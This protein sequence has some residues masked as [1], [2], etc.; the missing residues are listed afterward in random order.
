M[1]NEAESAKS[2]STA[3][4]YRVQ[5]ISLTCHRRQDTVGRD[6]PKLLVNGVTV[7]GPG[8]IGKGETVD[9]R[10]RSAV[11]TSVAHI[12]LTEVDAGS[13]DSLGVVTATA[14]QSGKGAQRGEYHLTNAD[15]EI[16]FQ[17][18]KA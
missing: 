7:Y 5:L 8:D 4:R 1:S 16:A 15:Y 9:L 10:P 6:E 12:A 14:G 13:D 3:G 2:G 11:F 17:V 18:V